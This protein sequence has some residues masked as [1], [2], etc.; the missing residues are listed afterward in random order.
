MLA[1]RLLTTYASTNHFA[2]NGPPPI[3]RHGNLF[4]TH[5]YSPYTTSF[6]SLLSLSLLSLSL[7]QRRKERIL[8]L[9]HEVR[10]GKIA[11]AGGGAGV[12]GRAGSGGGSGGGGGG[13]EGGRGRGGGARRKAKAPQRR[14]PS[15]SDDDYTSDSDGSW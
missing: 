7:L 12:A 10:M 6:R 14:Q 11:G 9:R 8:N 5:Q 4:Y 1:P 15:H 13:G 3:L 2:I